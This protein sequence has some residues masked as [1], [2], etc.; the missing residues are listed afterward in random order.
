M[1]VYLILAHFA[2][3]SL[4]DNANDP[5]EAVSDEEVATVSNLY[6]LSFLLV[7]SIYILSRLLDLQVENLILSSA[8]RC[9]IQISFLGLILVPLIIHDNRIL[10][11]LFIILMIFMAAVEASLRPTHVFP[12]MTLACFISLFIST[13][14]FLVLILYFALET[15]LRAQY[16][17]PLAGMIIGQGMEA[18]SVAMSKFITILVEDNSSIEAQLALGANRWEACA[19]SVRQAIRV[20]LSPTLTFMAVAGLVFI[21]G[22]LIISLHFNQVYYFLQLTQMLLVRL[23]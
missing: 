21:P 22:K 2:Q 3:A 7:S 11:F 4:A 20:G 16:A 10:V 1:V 23:L 15:G 19:E 14:V 9:F 6:L 12:A 5:Y 8:I 17:V 13:F 18:I